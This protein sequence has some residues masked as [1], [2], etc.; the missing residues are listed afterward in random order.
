MSLSP[1]KK[2]ALGTRAEGGKPSDDTTKL[3][4]QAHGVNASPWRPDGVPFFWVAK[5][6]FDK[7]DQNLER[8]QAAS[9]KLTY[10][11]LARVA[12]TENS[13]AFSKPIGYLATLASLERR[14]VEKRLVD[15]E[16]L[17]LVRIHRSQI[18]GTKARNIHHYTLTVL[19]RKV[20][21]QNR[22]LA[23][24]PSLHAFA[25]STE[26]QKDRR[27]PAGNAH[28][29]SLSI[30]A[31]IGLEKNRSLLSDRIKELEGDLYYRWQRKEH[32]AKVQELEA[33]RQQ[34]SDIEAQLL[35]T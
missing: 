16:R 6:A 21:N 26:V 17:E 11:A 31:R 3:P 7:I 34:L 33:A 9:A 10:I 35:T 32:P 2:P 28:A 23:N 8:G 13:G 14:T 18:E 29:I 5:E 4:A 15:L 12:C 22:K 19:F 25:V 30:A 20:P 24:A 1:N 27:N